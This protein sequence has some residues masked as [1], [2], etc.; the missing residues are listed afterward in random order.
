MMVCSIWH[1]WWYTDIRSLGTQY[2][3]SMIITKNV[4]RCIVLV[5]LVY[6]IIP[7]NIY[8]TIIYIY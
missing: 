6:S 1:A 4:Y 2:V 7:Y 8:N 3:Y 5:L